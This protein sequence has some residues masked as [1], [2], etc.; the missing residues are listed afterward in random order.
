MMN[1]KKLFGM[2]LK[3]ARLKRGI[4]QQQLAL[5]VEIDPAYVGR[6]ERGL[7]NVSIGIMETI[8]VYLQMEMSE[9]FRVPD[10]NESAPPPLKVGRKPKA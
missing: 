8:A 10:Q 1:A 5:D 4:S 3:N 7:E 2:N 6:I 9:M